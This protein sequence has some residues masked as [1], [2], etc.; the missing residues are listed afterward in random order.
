MAIA[1]ITARTLGQ[2]PDLIL[3]ECGERALERTFAAAKLP[4]HLIEDRNY[5]IPQISLKAFVAEGSRLLGDRD[6]GL[7]AAPVLSVTDY[8]LWSDY[9]LTAPTLGGALQRAREA[10]TLH[11]SGD[12]V[13][14]EPRGN[15]MRF[16]Y[17]FAE[18]RGEDYDNVAFVAAS[19]MLSIV[20]AYAGSG[21]RPQWLEFNIAPRRSV[22][23]I[24][25]TFGCIAKLGAET[26]AFPVPVR[27]LAMQR[28]PRRVTDVVSMEDVM[29]ERLRR[30]PATLVDAV[31]EQIRL[32]IREGQPLLDDVA[33]ALGMG[34]RTLQRALDADGIG[35]RSLAGRLKIERAKELMRL[36]DMSVTRVSLEL[37]YSTPA[38]FARAFQR[39]TGVPPGL[40]L[41]KL[42]G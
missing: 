33:L 26:V 12:C 14:L 23:R 24:E 37:S 40:F 10:V 7:L 3:R 36:P 29:R 21:W 19:I 1:T 28:P 2:M 18:S 20:R 31:S 34:P 6:I 9:V 41:S 32:R 38:N 13:A 11:A 27:M 15:H 25:D 16:T 8:G 42:P 35:F 4:L 17:R 22:Q 30:P 5:F 39:E